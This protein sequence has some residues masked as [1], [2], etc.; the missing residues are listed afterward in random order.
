MGKQLTDIQKKWIAALKENPPKVK[1][2]LQKA[3][4]PSGKM[5]FCCLGVY[6]KKIAKRK[7]ITPEEKYL[8]IWES[9]E[10]GLRDGIGDT[11][12]L[13]GLKYKG[14][15]L[16]PPGGWTITSLGSL[17]DKMNFDHKT[18]AEIIEENADIL[19]TNMKEKK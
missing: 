19:F 4:P 12:N 7:K 13:E 11:A 1:G 18:H 14:K 15:L 9:E 5:G 6:S 16:K 3:I 17:N 8:P 10:L 2:N